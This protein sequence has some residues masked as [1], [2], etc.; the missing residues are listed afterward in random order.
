M[1]GL[2]WIE[3]DRFDIEAKADKKYTI[4]ELPGVTRICSWTASGSSTTCRPEKPRPTS[5]RRPDRAHGKYDFT[6]IWLPGNADY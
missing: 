2:E 5:H 3:K 4:D 6:L 1:K